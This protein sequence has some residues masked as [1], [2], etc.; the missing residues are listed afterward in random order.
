MCVKRRMLCIKRT[1]L[2]FP[3]FLFIVAVILHE[4][5]QCTQKFATLG[6]EERPIL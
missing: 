5:Q 2:S 3:Q 6:P 1:L 4:V